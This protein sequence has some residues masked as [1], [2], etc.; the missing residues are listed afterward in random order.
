MAN[1]NTTNVDDLV[2]R[3]NERVRWTEELHEIFVKAALK[4]GPKAVPSRILAEMNCTAL[5]RDQVASHLQNYR[6]ILFPPAQVQKKQQKK[7]APAPKRKSASP[8]AAEA[9]A[10]KRVIAPAE[11]TPA[12]AARPAPSA[13][14]AA[15][16]TPNDNKE[17]DTT[18]IL[19]ELV[20]ETF[21]E[22]NDNCQ[23]VC[24]NVQRSQAAAAAPAAAPAP[25]PAP[26]PAITPLCL[27]T[28]REEPEVNPA[29]T[30]TATAPFWLDPALD[31]GGPDEFL[32]G[33]D[34]LFDLSPSG[35]AGRL[36]LAEESKQECR[37]QHNV[38][39]LTDL[40]TLPTIPSDTP[41]WVCTNQITLVDC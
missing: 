33:W 35:T 39:S 22:V 12:V 1:T 34:A 11:E 4:L 23:E 17:I 13:P 30:I 19:P 21:L 40:L 31:L 18:V 37:H 7:V 2:I 24:C 5:T 26:A 32:T 27:E 10:K 28:K 9:P 8:P 15:T 38:P 29:P 25:A 36:D 41:C 16:A 3:T 14:V 20:I 6:A